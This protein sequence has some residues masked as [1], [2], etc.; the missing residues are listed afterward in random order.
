MDKNQQMDY[1][2]TKYKAANQE[3]DTIKRMMASLR[4]GFSLNIEIE[5]PDEAV[6]KSDNEKD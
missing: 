1:L 5:R 4:G 3:V 2:L 6:L